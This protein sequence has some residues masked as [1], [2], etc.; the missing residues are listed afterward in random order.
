MI[1]HF[2]AET[3]ARGSDAAVAMVSA[4]VM[5]A[6]YPEGQRRFYAF[7]GGEFSNCNLYALTTDAAMDAA[8]AFEGG[9]Q[10]RKK[11]GR[12]IKAFGLSSFVLYALRVRSL[13]GFGQHLS[14]TGSASASTS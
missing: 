9:G 14:A 6:K 11:L 3:D 1:Q 12:I 5:K 7:A 10:F 2:C 13:D 8:R 4:P